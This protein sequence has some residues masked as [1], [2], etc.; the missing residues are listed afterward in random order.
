M[1][2][3]FSG[4]TSPLGP[5][6]VRQNPAARESEEAVD[7]PLTNPDP[8]DIWD[9]RS[10]GRG[11]VGPVD[12]PPYEPRRFFEK[13]AGLLVRPQQFRHPCGQREVA[14]AGP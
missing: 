11:P 6:A 9:S 3:V 7:S 2:K 8:P 1:E 13:P 5:H 12:P 4:L 14:I 10:S